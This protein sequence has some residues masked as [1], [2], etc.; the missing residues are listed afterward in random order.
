MFDLLIVQPIF[1]LL[2]LIY[3]LLPGHNFGLSIIIFT[4]I[5]R[6]L[7]WPL[8]KKQLHQVKVMRQIQPD[9]KRIKKAAKGNRQQE[10]LMMME[11]YKERGISPFGSIGI[12]LLQ[13]PILIGLYIGLQKVLKDPSALITFAYPPL[14]H[15]HW[16]EQL[17]NNIKQF[18]AT[19]FGL[20][21]L[22]RAAL[23]PQ[24]VYWPAMLL[25]LGSA[26]AQFFQSKQLSPDTKDARSLRTILKEASSGKQADQSEVNA[27]ITRSTRY[28]LPAMIFVF[29]VNLPS[30]LALYWF[31]SGIV[32]IVQQSIILKDDTAEMEAAVSSTKTSTKS[33]VIEG[34]V[35]ESPKEAAKPAATRRRKGSKVGKRRKK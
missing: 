29:T 24:G 8:I 3:A 20:M 9:L 14:Q 12:L 33:D 27:S 28:L 21:D 4:I 10:S 18:D 13:I 6:L 17:A 30:A 16:M 5:V 34:E 15:L 1:N 7:M 32:A 2:V 26:L 19:L 23:G 22:T 25:V 31:V 11:L 35:V